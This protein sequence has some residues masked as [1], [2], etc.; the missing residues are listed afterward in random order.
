MLRA[1]GWFCSLQIRLWRFRRQRFCL[2]SALLHLRRLLPR[3]EHETTRRA[4][5]RKGTRFLA[6]AA[7]QRRARTRLLKR[8]LPAGTPKGHWGSEGLGAA[9]GVPCGG[10][11]GSSHAPGAQLAMPQLAMPPR[12]LRLGRWWSGRGREV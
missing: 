9:G 12:V 10:G 7:V 5:G 2:K 11:L 1:G 3:L 8:R 6:K 4:Q